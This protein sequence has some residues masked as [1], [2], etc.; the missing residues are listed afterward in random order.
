MRRGLWH[1]NGY[2]HACQA[3][4]SGLAKT[5]EWLSDLMTV[6]VWVVPVT[7]LA[8]LVSPSWYTELLEIGGQ[9][10]ILGWGP[11]KLHLDFREKTDRLYQIDVTKS[12]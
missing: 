8:G 10:R 1:F 3:N 9:T 6:F 7:V 12:L 5:S 4:A 2:R 11:D